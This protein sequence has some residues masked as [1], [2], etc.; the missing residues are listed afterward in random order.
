MSFLFITGGWEFKWDEDSKPGYLILDIQ[1]SSYL[2]SSLIDVDI[3]PMYISIVIKG[4]L[5]RLRLPSEIKVT[6]SKC[7]RSKLTGESY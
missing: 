5:L 6:E 1:I 3:H 4:K 7:Q 2:D